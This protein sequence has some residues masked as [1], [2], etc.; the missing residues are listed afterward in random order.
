M[1]RKNPVGRAF[2]VI[3]YP[4]IRVFMLPEKVDELDIDLHKKNS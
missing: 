3:A 4:N 1:I 2:Y